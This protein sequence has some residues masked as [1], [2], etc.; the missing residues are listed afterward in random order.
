MSVDSCIALL[1][2]YLDPVESNIYIIVISSP[3]R[4]YFNIQGFR[5]LRI[6]GKQTDQINRNTRFNSFLSCFIHILHYSNKQTVTWY[7]FCLKYLHI[8]YIL[9]IPLYCLKNNSFPS[10]LKFISKLLGLLA[11]LHF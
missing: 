4:S 10:V 9:C 5:R 1:W 7:L 2:S 6:K 3:N 8:Y 11:K